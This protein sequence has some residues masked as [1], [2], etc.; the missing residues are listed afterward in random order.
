MD[1]HESNE[2]DPQ[3]EQELGDKVDS[4]SVA[5]ELETPEVGKA[6]EVRKATISFP[7]AESN[8]TEKT[9]IHGKTREFS[10]W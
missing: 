8:L 6:P 1:S 10:Y 2:L 3:T 9:T 7:D 5:G 4:S